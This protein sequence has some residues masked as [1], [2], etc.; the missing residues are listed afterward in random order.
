MLYWTILIL[1]NLPVFFLIGWLLFDNA[2][3]AAESFFTTVLLLLQAIFVPRIVRVFLDMD[4]EGSFGLFEF[5]VFVGG[6]IAV[7]YGEHFLLTNYVFG[8]Q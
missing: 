2:E 8:N 4:D 5:A 3:N 1:A 6:C 7:V